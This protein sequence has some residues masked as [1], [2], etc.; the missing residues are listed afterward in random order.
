[1]KISE[2]S[3][4]SS[5]VLSSIIISVICLFRK[6]YQFTKIADVK[7]FT[8]LYMIGF[9]RLFL[10]LDFEFTKGIPIEG[11][12]SWLW[13]NLFIRKILFL[14]FEFTVMQIILVMVFMISISHLMKLIITYIQDKSILKN[15]DKYNITQVKR[16]FTQIEYRGIKIPKCEVVQN[17]RVV[18]PFVT[19]ILEKKIVL[20]MYEYSDEDLFYILF[21][22]IMHIN[23]KDICI[24]IFLECF[25]QIFWWIPFSDYVSD[26]IEQTME[27]KCDLSVIERLN[28]IEKMAYMQTLINCMKQSNEMR[29]NNLLSLAFAVQENHDSMVERFKLMINEN[30]NKHNIKESVLLFIGIGG[31]CL[32]YLFVPL[33]RIYPEAVFIPDNGI[34]ITDDNTYIIC[35]DEKYYL[36]VNGLSRFSIKKE[37]VQY[38]MEAG[39]II[40]EGDS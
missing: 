21:H 27:I 1:M 3:C 16:I 4:I 40:K 2:F 33:P 38:A 20:P 36:V 19:G 12:F 8:V 18:M 32:S 13:N 34:L 6:R 26:D 15:A 11:Q 25:R 7:T 31:L 24:K 9:I 37:H 39:V 35:E 10:P 28:D 14:S 30:T 22:E 5:V 17:A 23:R 29:K